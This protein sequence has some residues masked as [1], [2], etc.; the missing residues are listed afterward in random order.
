MTV[1]LLDSTLREGEQTPGVDFTLD[2]KIE[3]ARALD[4]FGVEYVEAG[5]PAVSDSVFRAVREVSRLGLCAE[6]VAHSRAMKSDIDL[7]IQSDADWVGI[8]FSVADKRLEE[9]FRKNIDQAVS[10][11]QDCVAYAKAHGLKV[12]YT[13]EDT[14]RSDF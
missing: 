10:L 13:P 2:Q 1:E 4:D 7:A 5:H 6:V 12:R 14:V 11:I 9:H 8:F 3:I